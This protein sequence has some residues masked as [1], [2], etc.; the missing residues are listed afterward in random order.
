MA[1]TV[2]LVRGLGEGDALGGSSL[3]LK[4]TYPGGV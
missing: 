3:D 2:L 4:E 1:T